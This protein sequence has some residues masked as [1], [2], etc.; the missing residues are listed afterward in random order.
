MALTGVSPAETLK[1]GGNRRGRNP[2]SGQLTLDATDFRHFMLPHASSIQRC[3]AAGRFAFPIV[4][5]R[6]AGRIGPRPT[7]RPFYQTRVCRVTPKRLGRDKT[8]WPG[9]MRPA[10]EVSCPVR[11]GDVIPVVE[12]GPL[13]A[14]ASLGNMVRYAW[15]H[16][17]CEPWHPLRRSSPAKSAND[18]YCVRRFENSGAPMRCG[19]LS[20]R[21]W[22]DSGQSVP[23]MTRRCGLLSGR[24]WIES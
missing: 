4:R 11:V 8:S 15:N 16:Y 6:R 23:P 22:I 7:P 3:A 14:V 12:E 21:D 20:G 1:T 19:L 2:P 9:L 18:P 10:A 24:D 17:P 13:P 5:L